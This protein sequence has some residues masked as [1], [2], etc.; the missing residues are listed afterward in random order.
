MVTS[1]LT[2]HVIPKE[3]LLPVALARGPSG[4]LLDFTYQ[5]RDSNA[6]VSSFL[7]FDV[8]I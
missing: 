6:I 1:V 3:N 2:G 4:Q 7:F 8:G 5:S